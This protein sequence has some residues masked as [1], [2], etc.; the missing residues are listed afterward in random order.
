MP[1]D[2]QAA[3]RH[4]QQLAASFNTPVIIV[5]VP[6]IPVGDKSRPGYPKPPATSHAEEEPDSLRLAIQEAKQRL[7]FLREHRSLSTCKAG[8]ETKPRREPGRR[9][10][11]RKGPSP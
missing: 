10:S 5:P 4:A 9:S 11:K 3:M 7:S 1:Y 2:W 8:K 6:G